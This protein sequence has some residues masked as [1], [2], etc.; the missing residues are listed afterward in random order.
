LKNYICPYCK[1]A[2]GIGTAAMFDTVLMSR[3]TCDKCGRQFLIVNDV[4]MTEE[5]YKKASWLRSPSPMT[6]DVEFKI[7]DTLERELEP[8][9]IVQ[10]GSGRGVRF[11]DKFAG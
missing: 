10:L 2:T 9:Q 8:G 4:P 7:L 11:V 3:K 6:N 1:L 5:Q